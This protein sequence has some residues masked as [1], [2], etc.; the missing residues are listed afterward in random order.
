MPGRHAPPPGPRLRARTVVEIPDASRPGHVDRAS[1]TGP[2]SVLAPQT[3]AAR[4][5]SSALTF[6]SRSPSRSASSA[7]SLPTSLRKRKQSTTVRAGLVMASGNTFEGRV[8]DAVVQRRAGETDHSD[9]QARHG[10]TGLV[11][12]RDPDPRRKLGANVV[13]AQRGEQAEHGVRDPGAHGGVRVVLRDFRI[14]AAVETPR[15]PLDRPVV[16]EPTQFAGVNA[17][18]GCIALAEEGIQTQRPQTRCATP[19]LPIGK[20][21]RQSPFHAFLCGHGAAE[22]ISVA[23]RG[24]N[25]RHTTAVADISGRAGPWIGHVWAEAM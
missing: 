3:S 21:A 12:D 25:R 13:H 20:A 14:G 9:R 2:T 17:D 4:Q 10:R 23:P 19:D 16:H 1:M 11:R 6:R 18:L 7:T 5:I 22:T 15:D 8:H 24:S